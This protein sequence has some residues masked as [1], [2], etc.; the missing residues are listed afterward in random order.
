MDT[1]PT[2]GHLTNRGTLEEWAS[3]NLFEA[4]SALRMSASGASDPLPPE[5]VAV[6]R[7]TLVH[8]VGPGW[9]DGPEWS[10]R[11][12]EAVREFVL[13]ALAEADR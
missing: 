12:D 4:A 8:R 7:A 9:R 11:A 2:C 5:D 10:H 3:L 6:I 13:A 1:C